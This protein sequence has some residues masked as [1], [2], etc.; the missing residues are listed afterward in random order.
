MS[1]SWYPNIISL[2][3]DLIT[4]KRYQSEMSDLDF[5]WFVEV[6]YVFIEIHGNLTQWRMK[7]FEGRGEIG[8]RKAL[9]KIEVT[10]NALARIFEILELQYAVSSIL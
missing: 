5:F 8:C 10:G 2:T 7:I 9:V 3:Y 1:F 6:S 4:A